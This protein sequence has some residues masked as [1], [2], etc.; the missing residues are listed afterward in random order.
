MY[1]YYKARFF[2]Q[3]AKRAIKEG[4]VLSRNYGYVVRIDPPKPAGL[5]PDG[6]S[7]VESWCRTK[8]IAG[9]TMQACQDNQRLGFY[10]CPCGSGLQ[11]RTCSHKVSS[12][13]P[14]ACR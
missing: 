7:K 14:I 12:R 2:I 13:H 5:Q 11:K 10:G 9:K 4:V 8:T 3:T 6:T 1:D